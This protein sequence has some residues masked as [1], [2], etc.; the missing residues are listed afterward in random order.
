MSEINWVRNGVNLTVKVDFIEAEIISVIAG[1]YSRVTVIDTR[2]GFM[3]TQT[4]G[5]DSH[6]SLAKYKAELWINKLVGSKP[7]KDTQ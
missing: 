2:D 7:L 5:S 6:V 1:N 3:L 4:I